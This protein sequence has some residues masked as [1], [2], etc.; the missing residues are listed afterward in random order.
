MEAP[1]LSK[2]QS[3]KR[4][5]SISVQENQATEE[6]REELLPTPSREEVEKTLEKEMEE[7]KK[8]E[9]PK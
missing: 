1:Q 8:K 7:L 6:S 2:P 4:S 9:N 5:L 3:F